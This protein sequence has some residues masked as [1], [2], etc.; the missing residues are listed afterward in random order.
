MGQI[1]TH[2]SCHDVVAPRLV[3]KTLHALLTDDTTASAVIWRRALAR[4]DFPVSELRARV[5][6]PWQLVILMTDPHCSVRRSHPSGPQRSTPAARTQPTDAS[7]SVRV[8]S[9]A[10]PTPPTTASTWRSCAPCAP[11]A[12]PD[13]ARAAVARAQAPLHTL[14][15]LTRSC[16]LRS[17]GACAGTPRFRAPRTWGARL[18]RG[19][20]PRTAPL[21]RRDR[22]S[23][24]CAS[25]PPPLAWLSLS[26]SLPA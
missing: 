24:K 12:A 15:P 25:F 21:K 18:T 7:P 17:Y 23:A 19:S 5:L 4:A 10:V 9:T 8:H 16:A 13:A 22:V 3:N 26:L 20:R 1:C 11:R 6:K 14:H 2:L